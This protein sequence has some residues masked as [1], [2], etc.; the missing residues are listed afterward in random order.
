MILMAINLLGTSL[1]LHGHLGLF[2]K[3]CNWLLYGFACENL[4][5]YVNDAITLLLLSVSLQ[6]AN[7]LTW[8]VLIGWFTTSC[9]TGI[10]CHSFFSTPMLGMSGG[11]GFYLAYATVQAIV[12]RKQ[13]TKMGHVY[14]WA[15]L[16]FSYF[17]MFDMI[18]ST[19]QVHATSVVV[20]FLIVLSLKL[21]KRRLVKI[22][23]KEN[24]L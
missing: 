14:Q 24:T 22:G 10:I 15:I 20:G 6:L 4:D 9:L 5:A 21:T 3:H 13:Q 16:I 11:L 2:T 7:S 17:M 1:V 12:T 18:G 19:L 8:M 23:R